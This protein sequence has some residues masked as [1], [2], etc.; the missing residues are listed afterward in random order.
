MQYEVECGHCGF[1]FVLDVSEVPRTVKCA[2][3]GGTLTLAVPVPIGP[4]AP[5]PPAP[6]PRAPLP[7]P[8]LALPPAEPAPVRPRRLE[9]PWE[10]LRQA[11]HWA[12]ATTNFASVLVILLTVVTLLVGPRVAPAPLGSQVPT[13]IGWALL[14]LAVVHTACQALCTRAPRNY[15]RPLANASLLVL[16]SVGVGVL[17][18]S[19]DRIGVIAALMTG[20]GFTISFGFWLA[21][22]AQLGRSLGDDALARAARSYRVWLPFGL[23]LLLTF[24][25]LALVAAQTPRPPLVWFGRTAAS[26]LAIVL[27]RQYAA[28]LR[29]AVNALEHRAPYAPDP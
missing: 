4:P 12:R 8:A 17:S 3:C 2:V 15:G 14:L 27:F 28:V 19:P 7:P 18:W 10:T 22:L 11:L 9:H 29:L 6:K 5:P 16:P 20:V 13:G 1:Q 23:V 25:T 21:F 26:V 24:L